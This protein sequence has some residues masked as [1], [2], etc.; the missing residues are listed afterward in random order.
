MPAF[1]ISRLYQSMSSLS[2]S[3][4]DMLEAVMN[5]PP[6]VSVFSKITGVCPRFFSTRAHSMP[7]MPPPMTATF[8][9]LV[10]G[11]ILYLLCCMVCGVSAQRAR[12]IV[13]SMLCR[14]IVPLYLAMLKQPLWQRMQGLISSSRPS[15]SLWTHSWSTRFWRAMATASIL[16]SEMDFAATA[17]SILP[18]HTTGISQKFLM[19]ST[20]ARLQLFGMY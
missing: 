18:A 12:C 16:P 14:L 19:C 7:P 13:S 1:S 17:G 6:R 10:V 20:S 9:G 2:F 4:K 11:T 3:L 8:F 5:S 15:C